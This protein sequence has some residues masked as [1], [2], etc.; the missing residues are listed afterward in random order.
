MGC[1]TPWSWPRTRHVPLAL[2][3][4]RWAI[5]IARASPWTASSIPWAAGA[6]PGGDPFSY[7]HVA[8]AR[9]DDSGF[10]DGPCMV[11]C[12]SD[13]EMYSWHPGGTNALFGDGSVHFLKETVT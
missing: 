1:P 9:A 7:Y 12:T 10:R 8:G 6:A 11:N 4:A 13:N 3:A 2:T 5:T